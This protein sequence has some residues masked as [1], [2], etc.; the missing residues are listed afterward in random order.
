[1]KLKLSLVIV[2][3]CLCLVSYAQSTYS[4]IKGLKIF[5]KHLGE[6]ALVERKSGN[7]LPIEETDSMYVT[8]SFAVSDW[9]PLKSFH[10]SFGT[11][12][13]GDV[14]NTEIF[15]NNPT[16]NL[17]N[18]MRY[19]V[20]RDQVYLTI[21]RFSGVKKCYA[22]VF[23]ESINGEKSEPLK[24]TLGYS[25]IKQLNIKSAASNNTKNNSTTQQNE[26]PK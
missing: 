19:W 21:G 12:G 18:K 11:P 1:M 5:R 25:S 9:G 3:G 10:I 14:I 6:K 15:L 26:I 4:P 8:C 2:L 22:Q 17:P 16:D 23:A 24:I 20:V 7:S 13:Q